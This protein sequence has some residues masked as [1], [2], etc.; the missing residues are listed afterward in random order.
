MQRGLHLFFEGLRQEVEPAMRDLQDLA[1]EMEP[2]MRSFVDEMGPALRDLMGEIEDWS[3][4]HPPERLPNGD[5]LLRRKP[6]E[7][8]EAP[9]PADPGQAPRE[10]DI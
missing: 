9:T 5:I 4:Y 10:I 3:A 1:Q 6:P 8:R 7:K 2:A